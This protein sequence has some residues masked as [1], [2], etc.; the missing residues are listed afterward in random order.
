MVDEAKLDRMAEVIGRWWPE[1][2][3]HHELQDP[4]FIAKVEQ[5]RAALLDSLE[6]SSPI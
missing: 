4:A 2:V 5:A 3:S 6:L 1:Q